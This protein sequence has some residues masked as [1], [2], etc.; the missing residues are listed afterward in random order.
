MGK[1]GSK[2]HRHLALPL[3]LELLAPSSSDHILDV[4]CGQGVLAEKIAQ[5]GARYTGVDAS[6]KLLKMATGRFNGRSRINFIYGDATQLHKVAAL[7]NQ[8]FTGVTFLLSIQDMSPLAEVLA[9]VSARLVQNGRL[10]ILMTHP[11]FR[12]PRQS[13]W[14]WDENRKLRYRR[15]DH[16]LTKLQ[17]PMKSHRYGKTRSF[18][19]P[20]Q[21]YIN[22]LANNSFVIDQIRE[23]PVG[24]LI[25]N[26]RSK[27]EKRADGEI[28]LFLAIRA[29]KL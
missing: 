7:Q 19:R 25:K 21:T 5:A 28:P 24:D 3:L 10:I 12:I 29:R 4:G 27:A 13:G 2:H 17:V 16:Y 22:E 23:V 20:L 18:H 6:R 15:V 11:C 9:G 8:Q 26:K 1:Q 14:G